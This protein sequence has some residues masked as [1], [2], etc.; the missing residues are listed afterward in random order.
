MEQDHTICPAR[1]PGRPGE[2][3]PPA[4]G[5][6][7]PPGFC[8]C[9]RRELVSLVL[10]GRGAD[11]RATPQREQPPLTWVWRL[12]VPGRGLRVCVRVCA[13][14]LCVHVHVH[15]CVRVCGPH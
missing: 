13:R 7:G 1:P 3:S 12:P 10:G 5:L 8:T 9:P 15:A 11:L 2:R 14:V 6:A 4:P